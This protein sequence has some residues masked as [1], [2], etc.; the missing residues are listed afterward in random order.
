MSS[1]VCKSAQFRPTDFC[2][3]LTFFS[4]SLFLCHP[5]RVHV[6]NAVGRHASFPAL[7]PVPQRDPRGDCRRRA[8]RSNR[9]VYVRITNKVTEGNCRLLFTDNE[10][11][12]RSSFIPPSTFLRLCELLFISTFAY[13]LLL[14]A[15]SGRQHLLGAYKV[16]SGQSDSAHKWTDGSHQ[17]RL[18]R[19]DALPTTLYDDLFQK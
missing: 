9:M 13:K 2:Y 11:E 7:L 16:C 17:L 6:F 3:F 12:E 5:T 8:K 14:R 15:C 1:Q 19:L 18:S 10:I 4:S